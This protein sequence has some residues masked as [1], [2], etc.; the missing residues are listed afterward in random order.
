VT[1]LLTRDQYHELRRYANGE[2]R[3]ESQRPNRNLIRRNLL[4]LA[5]ASGTGFYRITEAGQ[6]VLRLGEGNAP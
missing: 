1:T 5:P 3:R 6:V 2:P 4:T